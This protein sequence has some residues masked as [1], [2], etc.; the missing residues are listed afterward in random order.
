MV[1]SRAAATF[2][3]S[4]A[5]EATL[6]STAVTFSRARARFSSACW[7]S[8]A[9]VVPL[10]LLDL[11][12]LVPV[13]E[14][15]HLAQ[16]ALEGGAERFDPRRHLA[17]VA[18][19]VGDPALVLVDRGGG[20]VALG[21]E[22]QPAGF[23]RLQDP[24]VPFDLL[25]PPLGGG[26][27]LGGALGDLLDRLAIPLQ[28][29]LAPLDHR[30]EVGLAL[31][32]GRDLPGELVQPLA[33]GGQG[34]LVA[35][36]VGSERRLPR[37]GVG[38]P[39]GQSGEAAGESAPAAEEDL[40]QKLPVLR[41]LL[42][43]AA[44]GPGLAL[45]RAESPLDL[46]DDVVEPQEVGGRLLELDLGHVLPLLVAGDPRRLLD[47]LPPLLGLA[48]EDHPDLPLLDDRV[49][50]DAEPGV[51][52]EVADV[53]QAHQL[54][55]QP[56]LALAAAEDPAADG[57]PPLLG[58]GDRGVGQERERRLRHP[59]RLP[60]V[61]AVED[62]V[63]HGR[64]AEGFGALLAQD[65]GHGVREVA[66]AAAVG[67]DDGGDPAGELDGDRIDEGFEAGDLEAF[68]FQHG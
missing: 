21:R 65:P 56:V 7:S 41:F 49:G 33:S 31:V 15:V 29:L 63:L 51:H 64:A 38:D 66:L 27:G 10:L 39:G 5:R 4:A 11:G 13:S 59:Q 14:S 30:R 42:L 68:Q 18:L 55:V 61:G 40:L 25:P 20:L 2:S 16:S 1:A 46:G 45:E 62:D 47:Q 43:V 22:L 67:A 26:A 44:G 48:G 23:E 24:G 52:Q 60:A 53:F 32:A 58:R 19:G 12:L 3:C 17:E 34:R 37:V 28:E 50:A 35:V 9:S 8:K 54:A 6:A 57:D 36:E